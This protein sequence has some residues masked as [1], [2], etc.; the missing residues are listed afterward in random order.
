[1]GEIVACHGCWVYPDSN[2][3]GNGEHPQQ[4]YTV[5]FTS[6]VLWGEAGDAN[7]EVCLDLF[8]PYLH[9]EA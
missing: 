5:A 3:H 4:L 8:E 9:E 7:L 2:S 6:E 1:V